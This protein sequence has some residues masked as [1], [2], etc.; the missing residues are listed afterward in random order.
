MLANVK[1]SKHAKMQM[2]ARNISLAVVESTIESPASVLL[3]DD[4]KI[5]QAISNING[6]NYLIRVFVN[7]L[8]QPN[9]VITVYKTSKINKYYENKI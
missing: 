4:K 7:I 5:Y 8:E 3:E 1:I 2:E 9:V 6:Q